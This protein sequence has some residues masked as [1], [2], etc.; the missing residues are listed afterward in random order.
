M[1]YEFIQIRGARQHNLKNIN[2]DIPKNKL[3]VI[4]GLSGSGKSSLAFD[5]IYAEGQRRYV[6]SL[7]T[8]ARQFLELM[9]KPDVDSIEGLSPAISIE[10][11]TVSKNPRST[12]ATVTE[13][14][15]YLRI[16]YAN[17]G[18]VY[19]YKC[20]RKITQQSP[21]QI[22]DEIMK[23]PEKTK[24]I[25]YAPVV[26]QKKGEFKAL[27]KDLLKNG[28]TRVK[29][30]GKIHFLEEEINIDKNKK[31][32]IDVIIDRLIIKKGI[33]NRLTDS[34][35]T[36]LNL[37][38]GLIKVEIVD[39]KKEIFFSEKFACIYCSISYPEVSAR[40][41]SFNNPYGACPKC[42]GIGFITEI[43]EYSAFQSEYDFYYIQD[44]YFRWKN[45][46]V[47][48]EKRIKLKN[49]LNKFLIEKTCPECKGARLKKEALSVKFK[50]KNIYE[51][52]Q[53][54]V[55]DALKFLNEQKF[56]ERELEIG[57]KI[58]S[59][60]KNRLEF[61]EKV[62]LDYITLNRRSSTLSGGESQRIRL[63]AQIGS[64]L[65][66][67]IYVLDEPSI[68]LHPRDTHKLIE[69][70]KNLKEAGNTVIVVEHDIDIIK[71]ADF[72]I[73]LG[74]E[75]GVKGGYI[76]AATTPDKLKNIKNSYTGKYLS[77]KLKISSPKRIKNFKKFI[78]IKGAKAFNL[79]NINVKIPVG[80]FVCITGVSGS[81]KST[82][83]NEVIYKGLRKILN[84]ERID[85]SQLFDEIETNGLINKVIMIDQSPIGRT[86][87]SNPATYTGVFT[88]IREL[89]SKVPLAKMRGYKPGRFSFNV[90]GGRCEKC[91]GDGM[92][93]L[94]MLF[95]PEVYIKCDE[96]NGKRFNRDTLQVKYKD[97]SIAD[98]LDMTVNQ[99][100]EFFKNIPH[101]KRKLEVL[102]EVG[103]GYLKL[104]QPAPTLSGG[105][106]QRIKLTK[107]LSKKDTGKTIYLLDEPTTGLHYYD[108]KNLLKV[109]FMLRDKGNTIVVIEH[110]L[111]VIKC[112]DY[113]IDLGPEGG[114]KGGE[115]VFAGP[116]QDLVKC[117]K[118]YTG[119]YLYS[120]SIVAGGLEDIS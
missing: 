109:L 46:E 72:V 6:E 60:I 101:I 37:A 12:V 118:S 3:V 31:H 43:D 119:K 112:A 48:P 54:T 74:P 47:S 34:I 56:T 61:L 24:I 115:V 28:F 18:E 10:Q 103:L 44:A 69:T 87:R 113:I 86:P 15:D 23:F 105:E 71:S 26:R 42:K 114:D 62:G 93:K 4:T 55:S 53:L 63:A 97:K 32:E 104:G 117:E 41:F 80:A 92:I 36:G 89:F 77:G 79:K 102:K 21:Q 95:M 20:G 58:I 83:L 30:D 65:S 13:I 88:P 49:L 110:N 78:E 81:G 33:E 19:C 96:C 106:A 7:S 38:N 14:Y 76:V 22:V 85:T 51:F 111:E 50:G 108:I 90:K 116:P 73:D 29:V 1:A 94:E 27:F 45:F 84:R 25:I 66:G 35:E 39:E 75:P 17:L 70:L 8:Y 99:A 67:V 2:I 9:E 16:L 59:E 40:L 107:E 11:K 98:V 100:Y 91:K 120:H 64:K 5:T 57:G 68:G 82:L 52:T